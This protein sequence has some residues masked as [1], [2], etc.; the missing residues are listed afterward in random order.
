MYVISYVYI[1]IIRT[2]SARSI[3]APAPTRNSHT[4]RW[5]LLE[6]VIKGVCPCYVYI[7]IC[8][9]NIR[10]VT[11]ILYNRQFLKY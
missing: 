6:A 1:V 4:G 8:V 5:P 11:L 10:S 7:H 3:S 2:L 9:I